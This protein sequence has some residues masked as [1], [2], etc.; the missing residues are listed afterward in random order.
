MG[1]K[2]YLCVDVDD[3]AHEQRLRD[4]LKPILARLG[5]TLWGRR[6]MQPG[7]TWKEEMKTHLAQAHFFVVLVSSNCLA[8]DL[9]NVEIQ[10]ALYRAARNRGLKIIPILI[11]PCGFEWSDLAQFPSLPKDGKS[12][13]SHKDTDQAWT[14]VIRDLVEMIGATHRYI[15]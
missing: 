7:A 1:Y 12:I 13:T 3:L 2:I 15:A 8:S 4:G 14:D 6:D 9:C 11:R 10:R 5:L